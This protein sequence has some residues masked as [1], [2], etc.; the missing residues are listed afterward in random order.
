M[1][2]IASALCAALL[3]ILI[4]LGVLSGIPIAGVVVTVFVI[5]MTSLIASLAFFMR[6]VNLSL[7]ALRAKLK[8]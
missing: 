8:T 7:E 2:A 6:D 1:L 5:G 3:V 4:F